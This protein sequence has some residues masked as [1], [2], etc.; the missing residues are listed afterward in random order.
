[1]PSLTWRNPAGGT[2]LTGREISVVA[3]M[4]SFPVMGLD[5][6]LRTASGR[7]S[8]E[9]WVTNSLIMLPLFAIGVW[10]GDWIAGLAGLG[11]ARRADVLKRALLVA[12]LAALA[13]VPAWF[14]VDKSDNPITAQPL[15]APQAHDSGDVYWVAPWVVIML[16]CV[17]LAPA[18]VWV[19]GAIGRR[20]TSRITS[21]MPRAAAAFTQAALLLP[22]LTAA[23]LGAWALHQAAVRAYASQVYY[24]SAPAALARQSLPAA[25]V[26][27]G[28]GA[29]Q[30][31]RPNSTPVAAPF[32]FVY[33]AAHALQD[34]LAGQ[35]VGLP[36][37]VI[38]L[39]R[40]TREPDDR[41]RHQPAHAK[42]GA[43]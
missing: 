37:A 13:Q 10:A 35:A 11:T 2:R 19:S 16:V 28:A 17:C 38:A 4:L 40:V 12:L 9:Q 36:V 41:N 22:L 20:I 24:T 21:R 30:A 15:V 31:S 8:V 34:G 7:F 18:A 27:T 3:L 26:T 43:T 32:A 39:L 6:L 23:A 33:Q 14:E 1:M 25:A 29:R 5:Q 42:G